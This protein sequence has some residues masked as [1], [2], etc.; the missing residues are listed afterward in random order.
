M[1]L[2]EGD[3]IF[4]KKTS[5][6][7]SDK[8]IEWLRQRWKYDNHAKYQH[9][10]TEWV[11]NITQNQADSFEKQMLNLENNVLGTKIWK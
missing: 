11:N 7:I 4:D 8:L 6:K 1:R 3:Y 5:V 10:F 9:Y 2:K